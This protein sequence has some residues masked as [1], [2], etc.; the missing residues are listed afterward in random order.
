MAYRIKNKESIST[1]IKRIACEQTDEAIKNLTEEIRMSS[2]DRNI[3]CS[4][5]AAGMVE[6]MEAIHDV[7]KRIKKIRAVIRLVRDDLG[8]EVYQQENHCFRDAGRNLSE[9]RDA[10]VL[11]ETFNKL[12]KHFA[13]FINPQGFTDLEQIL[14]EHQQ[15]TCKQVLKEDNSVVETLAEI[16]NARERISY[17]SL[18]SSSGASILSNGLHRVYKHG[19]QDCQSVLEEEQPTAEMLHDWRKR[20][21]YLW[22]HLRIIRPIWSDLINEWTNQTKQLGEYLGDDHD[23]AVLHEFI[24]NQQ[25]VLK[26]QAE[27]EVFNSLINRRRKQLQLAAKSLGK[28]IYV[29]SP[30]IFVNR[31]E[32]YW[33]IWQQESQQLN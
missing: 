13:D 9:I 8:K 31:I 21:K 32:A 15:S 4:L 10:Q 6:R 5:D 28:R 2:D 26:N 1:G 14:V 25:E 22:Y 17:W 11:L 12:E 30:E 23:L 27:L 7:R 33:Q 20:V 24:N 18:E 29:E 16:K 3:D 19:Y